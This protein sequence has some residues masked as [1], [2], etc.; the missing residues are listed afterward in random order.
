MAGCCAPVLPST[1]APPGAKLYGYF[2]PSVSSAGEHLLISGGAHT[3][4]MRAPGAKASDTSL[5]MRGVAGFESPPA[6]PLRGVAQRKST[7]CAV[8][9]LDLGRTIRCVRAPPCSIPWG[10]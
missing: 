5:G 6:R 9:D 3:Q 1:T 7:Y 8:A 4:L 2:K 10:E